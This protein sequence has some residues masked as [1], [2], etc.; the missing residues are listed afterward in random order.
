[1]LSVPY[2]PIWMRRWRA[3][4]VS[5]EKAAAVQQRA[6]RS[7]EFCTL[8]L[9]GHRGSTTSGPAVTSLTGAPPHSC[10]FPSCCL[11][12][13]RVCCTQ[14]GLLKATCGATR[15]KCGVSG[16][17]RLLR[18]RGRAPL[19]GSSDCMSPLSVIVSC[20][21][22]CPA[23]S[24]GRAFAVRP[25]GGPRPPPTAPLRSDN[26]ATAAQLP[27]AIFLSSVLCFLSRVTHLPPVVR[28]LACR[29]TRTS[30][31]SERQSSPGSKNR[32]VIEAGADERPQ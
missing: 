1:M 12:L 9:A 5:G 20:V 2:F 14:S 8:A 18:P 24:I 11:L 25:S 15:D 17:P 28:S 32:D 10:G 22:K 27:R 16:G 3:L 26:P 21:T 19:D 23:E 7:L 4:G 30:E 6:G 29:A 13:L 31:L